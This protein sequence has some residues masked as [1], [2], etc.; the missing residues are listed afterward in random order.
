[1]TIKQREEDKK[2]RLETTIAVKM[3]AQIRITTNDY[4]RKARFRARTTA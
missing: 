3:V 1:M 2:E 4:A